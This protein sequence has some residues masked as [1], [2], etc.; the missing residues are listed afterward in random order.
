[1]KKILYICFFSASSLFA[2]EMNPIVMRNNKINGTGGTP[3]AINP[4]PL[5]IDHLNYADNSTNGVSTLTVTD[6]IIIFPNPT[7]DFI[8]VSKGTHFVVVNSEGKE[9]I[10]QLNNSKLDFRNLPSDTYILTIDG[11][12][13]YKL[14]KQ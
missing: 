2:Q 1:M 3:I 4:T 11:K 13:T 8:Q 10:N 7:T 5:G 12:S 14:I 9:V 6:G